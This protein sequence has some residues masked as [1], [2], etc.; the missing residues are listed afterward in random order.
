MPTTRRRLPRGRNGITP[1][2]LAAMSRNDY[3]GLREAL[4]IPGL[5]LFRPHP[6]LACIDGLGICPC[7]PPAV[8]KEPGSCWDGYFDET[9]ELRARL[10]DACDAAGLPRPPAPPDCE[11]AQLEQG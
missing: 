4:G 11:C 8:P 9:V 2:A 5:G 10:L 1:D 6:V 3:A 7:S